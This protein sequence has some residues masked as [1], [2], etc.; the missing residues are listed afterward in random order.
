[1][2]NF[3]NVYNSL[4]LVIAGSTQ[5]ELARQ[6]S[7]L[8][9]ENAILRSKLPKRISLTEREKNR[10]CRFAKNLGKALDDIATIVHAQTIRRWIREA[11]KPGG[12]K[13]RKVGRKR[14]REDIEKLVL[15]L[16]KDNG[17]GYTRILGEL[18]KLGIESI[19]RNTVK[20]ILIRGGYET[21]PKR[22]P[23][24][25]DD[26]LKRHAKTLWQCDFFSKKVVTPR[27]LKDLYLLVFLHVESRRVFITPSTQHPNEAWVL[28]Q[29]VAFQEHAESE[30]I[31]V[32]MVMHDRD[33][34]FTASFDEALKNDGS[35][36][37]KSAFRSPNQCAYVERF[38]Q[39]LQQE[40]LDHFFVFGEAHMDHLCSEFA[41]HYHDER[42]HQGLGNA[43]PSVTM[44]EDQSNQQCEPPSRIP[45]TDV[46]CKQRLGGMLKSYTRHVA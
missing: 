9:V 1:M 29:T 15:K 13:S 34:K 5:R 42:P 40:C 18:K 41:E 25:W 4:I 2:A 8:K 10:L 23:G 46:R 35:A 38:I 3:R 36:I 22:G 30:G 11:K 44:A 37:R 27:G 39:T 16:A 17:W 28:D 19:T 21:G 12:L 6:V 32:G 14:T 43:R 33:T 26:F 24:T 7:Y 45:L 31:E 20:A